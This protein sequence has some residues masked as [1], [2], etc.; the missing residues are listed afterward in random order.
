MA[1]CENLGDSVVTCTMSRVDSLGIPIKRRLL[2]PESRWSKITG[3]ST[4]TEC[5]AVMKV[6]YK[7]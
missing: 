3:A 1:A 7:Y 6:L 2:G 5:F 4:K